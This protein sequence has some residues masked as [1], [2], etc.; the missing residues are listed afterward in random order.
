MKRLF[1]ILFFTAFVVATLSAQVRPRAIGARLGGG[2]L[3]SAEFSYQQATGE[4]N[5]IEIDLGWGGNRD[6]NRL[7]IVGIYHWVYNIDGG[8]NWY[9]GPG[10]ALGLHAYQSDPGYLNI[11]LGGQLGVEYDFTERG[12]NLLVSLDVRPMWDFLGKNNGLGWGSSFGI[13]YLF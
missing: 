5:R 11:A 6:W 10:A 9:A 13:R 7:N 1:S 8:F 4:A 12:T 2:S 3:G